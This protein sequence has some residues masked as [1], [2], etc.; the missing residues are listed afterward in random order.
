MEK[1]TIQM[2]L[3]LSVLHSH[4]SK[5][6]RFWQL[7]LRQFVLLQLIHKLPVEVSRT[8]KPQNPKRY[9]SWLSKKAVD[10][11]K[12]CVRGWKDLR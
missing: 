1:V 10:G 11:K 6:L 12:I 4:C 7:S 5:P 3:I 2:I 9:I 8:S